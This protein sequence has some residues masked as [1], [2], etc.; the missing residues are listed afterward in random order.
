MI[1]L[2]SKIFKRPVAEV[3]KKMERAKIKDFRTRK[4]WEEKHEGGKK[5][6]WMRKNMRKRKKTK[7][8]G[9]KNSGGEN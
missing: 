3:I 2:W 4:I 5:I 1:S 9:S 7:G 6:K 8:E